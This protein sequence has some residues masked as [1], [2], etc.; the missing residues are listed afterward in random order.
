[1]KK[2]IFKFFLICLIFYT[3]PRQ[4]SAQNNEPVWQIT[5]TGAPLSVSQS[6][7][8]GFVALSDS[9]ALTAV[10]ESG[11]LL[12]QI[13]LSRSPSPYFTVL[14]TDHV[15]L[16][17]ADKRT[18]SLFNPDGMV[19]WETTL[20]FSLTANPIWC[21]NGVFL[22]FGTNS[23]CA[24]SWNGTLLW[25][26]SFSKPWTSEPFWDGTG[27]LCFPFSDGNTTFIAALSPFGKE[28]YE[29]N[30]EKS[31][32]KFSVY[33]NRLYALSENGMVFCY[34][35]KGGSVG[36]KW[37]I[38]SDVFPQ[39]CCM[40]PTAS[41]LMMVSG[42]GTMVSFRSGDGVEINRENLWDTPIDGL[43]IAA[44]G[45]YTVI[46]G[47]T[48]SRTMCYVLN[49]NGSVV[50]IKNLTSKEP[51]FVTKTGL[52]CQYKDD[53]SITAWKTPVSMIT[54]R[55]SQVSDCRNTWGEDAVPEQLETTMQV[56]D[57]ICD[58]ALSFSAVTA[59][60]QYGQ[61]GGFM[62]H[63]LTEIS[64]SAESGYDFSGWYS[65]IITNETNSALLKQTLAAAGKAPID[66]SRQV[67]NAIEL[68]LKYNR[69]GIFDDS[70][71]FET[72]NT[73][74]RICLFMGTPAIINQG[75]QILTQLIQPQYG[76]KVQAE[77]IETIKKLIDL[78]KEIQK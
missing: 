32:K 51:V 3:I 30:L 16:A 19:K 68:R 31:F 21:D 12:R 77:A 34:E 7:S 14:P 64:S 78:Q 76:T 49:D 29:L 50:W 40:I 55:S 52:L 57:G 38:E 65:R 36:L 75:Q 26:Y 42:N 39:N 60:D 33:K 5:L 20:P 28:V 53:W 58:R 73:V 25:Q 24:V 48:I 8:Y 2:S 56:L 1:M 10:T 72:C 45:N 11:H 22:C 61:L 59:Q 41:R 4:I 13:F 63:Y 9:K 35:M 67:L 54:E 43:S 46:T 66:S 15:C 18:L 17:Y 47:N 62:K 69:S 70:L 6:T 37:K 27:L 23:V 71:C 44:R 74:Y